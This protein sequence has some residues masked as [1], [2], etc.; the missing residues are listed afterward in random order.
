MATGTKITKIYSFLIKTVI[1]I[2]ALGFISHQLL[3]KYQISD[4]FKQSL[5]FSKKENFYPILFLVFLLMI[6]NWGIEAVKWRYLIRK[7]EKTSFLKSFK[8]VLSGVTISIYTPNRVGE[9]AGRIFVLEKANRIE[10]S[11]IT[12]IGSLSQLLITVFLGSI[13]FMYVYFNS[14]LVISPIC[15]SAKRFGL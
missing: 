11:L 3:N 15:V 14:K 6:V 13:S 8:A 10:A 2:V 7:V 1:I 9:F 12:V 4:I 5:K